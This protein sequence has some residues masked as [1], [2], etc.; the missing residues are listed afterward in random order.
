MRDEEGVSTFV[1]IWGAVLRVLL[2][3][4]PFEKFGLGPYMHTR[5]VLISWDAR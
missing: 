5:K 3:K 2:C 1:Q 4:Y